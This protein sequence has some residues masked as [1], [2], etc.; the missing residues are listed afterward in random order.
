MKN[1]KEFLNE[2][3]ELKNDKKVRTCIAYNKNNQVSIYKVSDY[4]YIDPCYQISKLILSDNIL[5]T[6]NI[7][8]T[9]KAM[10]SFDDVLKVSELNKNRIDIYYKNGKKALTI[11]SA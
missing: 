1:I 2:I 7:E 8:A 5:K 11:I 9:K 6:E 3:K 4:E 10:L